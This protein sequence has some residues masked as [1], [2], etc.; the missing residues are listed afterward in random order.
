VGIWQLVYHGRLIRAAGVLPVLGAALIAA[1]VF[2]LTYAAW[3]RLG[4]GSSAIEFTPLSG[5]G[6]GSLV[7]WSAM[8]IGSALALFGPNTLAVLGGAA[9]AAMGSDGLRVESRELTFP[10]RTLVVA[11]FLA[12]VAWLLVPI[13][14]PIGLGHSTLVDVPISAAAAALLM[15]PIAIA[16]LVL[17]SPF[18]LDRTGLGLLLA[19][20]AAALLARTAFP[21]F[22]VGME[23]WRTLL[24]PIGVVL[25]FLAACT[26][27]RGSLVAVAA[28][29]AGISAEMTG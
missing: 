27:R 20:V 17:V 13:A 28:L 8:A 1:A 23:G 5:G 24:L 9:I 25:A 3:R 21:L 6:T 14:G 7:A 29:C 11:G 4:R 16:A 22:A 12:Y 19:P 18:P 2:V 26:G 10:W 15:P